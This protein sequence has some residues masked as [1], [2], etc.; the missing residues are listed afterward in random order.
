MTA[1]SRIPNPNAGRPAAIPEGWTPCEDAGFLDLVGPIYRRTGGTA[2]GF[3]FVAEEKHANLL[4]LVHGGMLMT[5]ADRALGLTA[6]EAAE[7]RPSVT[8]QFDMQ[9]T[10][11]ARIG[12]FVTI[13]PEVLRRTSSLV[14]MRGT[15]SVGDRPIGFANGIW[16]ILDQR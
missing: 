6:W 13:E 14:F 10:S 8:I 11:A 1:G 16:K 2:S 5:L 4:G 15:L 7:G 9:F 3:G 12:E